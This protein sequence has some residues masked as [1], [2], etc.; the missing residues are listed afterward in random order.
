[1]ADKCASWDLRS[2]RVKAAPNMAWQGPS[3]RSAA[4]SS[5]AATALAVSCILDGEYGVSGAA[6]GCRRCW[7]VVA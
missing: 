1:M 3:P 6:A 7:P 2:T 4:I 5:P